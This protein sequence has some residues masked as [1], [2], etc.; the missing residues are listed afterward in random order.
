M[1]VV[2]KLWQLQKHKRTEFTPMREMETRAATH[3]VLSHVCMPESATTLDTYILSYEE[4]IKCFD[5]CIRSHT[6]MSLVLDE[7]CIME[8]ALAHR[9][10]SNV[11]STRD[12]CVRQNSSPNPVQTKSD[13]R[14]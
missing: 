2:A 6:S 14:Q 9:T 12:N 10:P 5:A 8:Y 3:I 4:F 13:A 7:W 1:P 11:Q